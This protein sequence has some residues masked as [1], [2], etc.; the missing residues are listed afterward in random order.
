MLTMQN[1]IEG[2]FMTTIFRV[3]ATGVFLTLGT[4][5]FAQSRHLDRY[6][7]VVTPQNSIEKVIILD[8]R[9]GEL[10]GWSESSA[11]MYLGKIFPNAGAGTLARIIQVNP[12][13][14]AR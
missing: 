7:M 5:A 10:W 13:G 2:K 8:K 11:I 9:T 1:V 14:D 6:E 3:M 12:E 4:Q